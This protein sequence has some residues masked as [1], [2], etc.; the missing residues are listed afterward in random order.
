[1]VRSQ[2]RLPPVGLRTTLKR[3]LGTYPARSLYPSWLD[4]S[5]EARLRLWNRWPEVNWGAPRPHPTRPGAFKVVSSPNW[6]YLFEGYDPGVTRFPVGGRP[7]RAG[8]GVV[9]YMRGLTPSCAGGPTG[10]RPGGL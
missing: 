7:G 8:I 9:E 2:H 3:L 1:Y 6:A 4:P 5:F 10:V